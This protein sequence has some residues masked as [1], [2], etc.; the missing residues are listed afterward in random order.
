L[1]FFVSGSVLK[2]MVGRISV[3]IETQVLATFDAHRQRRFYPGRIARPNR[4]RSSSST[5]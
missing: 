1:D 5:R 2:F 4:R 3:G